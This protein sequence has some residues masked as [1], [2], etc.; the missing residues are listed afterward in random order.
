MQILKLQNDG[1]YPD[2]QADRDASDAGAFLGD[3]GESSARMALITHAT[4]RHPETPHL[5]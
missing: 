3:S 5:R 2:R 4:C 1:A